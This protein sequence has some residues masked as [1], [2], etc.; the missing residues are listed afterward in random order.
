M[1]NL[2][3]FAQPEDM[4]GLN[5]GDYWDEA[6]RDQF[7]ATFSAFRTT[8]IAQGEIRL[9]RRDG[10]PIMVILTGRIERDLEGNP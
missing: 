8:G 2:L 3:G 1:T 4:I 7:P 5:F 10:S 6:T 9:R